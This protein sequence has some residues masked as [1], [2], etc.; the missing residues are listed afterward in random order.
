MPNTD[1][2]EI[3]AWV[4]LFND[5]IATDKGLLSHRVKYVATLDNGY[6]SINYAVYFG[7]SVNS[8]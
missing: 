3:V 2:V 4:A 7:H 5:D 6:S 1:D 8:L